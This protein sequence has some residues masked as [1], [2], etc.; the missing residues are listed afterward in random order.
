MRKSYK[1]FVEHMKETDPNS[2][3]AFVPIGLITNGVLGIQEGVFLSVLMYR[4][5]RHCPDA[6]EDENGWFK[7]SITD[8]DWPKSAGVQTR[9]FNELEKAGFVERR[10]IG[11]PPIRYVRIDWDRILKLCPPDPKRRSNAVRKV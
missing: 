4:Q 3:M 5:V 2:E 11:S 1:E 7:C 8:L 6:E 10:L 9:R